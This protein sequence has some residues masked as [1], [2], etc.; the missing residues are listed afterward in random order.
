MADNT[1]DTNS[2][3]S[4]APE[5]LFKPGSEPA[6]GG[7]GPSASV[8]VGPVSAG[9]SAG[10]GAGPGELVEIGKHDIS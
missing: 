1:N 9:V 8:S 3:I 7:G 10:G 6:S 5:R 4:Q 2:E